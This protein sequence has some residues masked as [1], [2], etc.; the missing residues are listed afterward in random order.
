VLPLIHIAPRCSNKSVNGS[1]STSHSS[2]LIDLGSQTYHALLIA[3]VVSGIGE[4]S[5]QCLAPPF[6]DDAASTTQKVVALLINDPPR[7]G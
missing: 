2:P 7:H 4:A 3:R 5:F 6:I 1:R